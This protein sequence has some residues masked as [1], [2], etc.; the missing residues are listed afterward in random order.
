MGHLRI[1]MMGAGAV[2]ILRILA[3]LVPSQ[4]A[5]LRP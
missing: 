1:V 2:I 3:E 5:Y 4:S